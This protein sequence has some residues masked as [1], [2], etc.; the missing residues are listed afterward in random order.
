MTNETTPLRNWHKKA[1]RRLFYTEER[2]K[3]T[4]RDWLVMLAVTLCYATVAFTNLGVHQIAK[5]YYVMDTG[6]EVRVAFDKPEDIEYIKYY[7]SRVTGTKLNDNRKMSVSYSL[8]GEGYTQ[9]EKEVEEKD[10]EGNAVQTMS[11]E[12]IDHAFTSMYEWQFISVSF[13]AKYV[14]IH[15]DKGGLPIIEMAF[16]DSEGNPVKVASAESLEPDAESGSDVWNMFDEQQYVPLMTDYMSE[17]YFD[18][19]YH[20]RTGYEY[21]TH[22]RV[23][24]WTHPP[25]G[26]DILSVGI[27]I[28]GMN[29]FGWRCMGT[30]FG[31]LMLP[32]MYVLGKRMF[33]KTLYAFI[34]T[35]LMAVDFMHYTQ[36]RIATIDSYSVF[37]IMLMY[38][39]MYLYTETNYNREPLVNTLLPLSL[40]GVAFGLGAATKWL[41][42]YA[43][44]GLAVLLF[45]QLGKRYL[46]YAY[47]RRMLADKIGSAVLSDERRSYLEEITRGYIRRTLIT[48]LWCVLFFIIVPLGLYIISY[49]PYMAP[50]TDTAGFA[51]RYAYFVFSG[52]LILSLFVMWLLKMR[53]DRRA[54]EKTAAGASDSMQAALH[55][56][57]D[58]QAVISGAVKETE[59]PQKRSGNRPQRDGKYRL[60]RV[61]AAVLCMLTLAIVG[62]F[63]YY[64]SFVL[65]TD[66]DE[67]AYD[68]EA[69]LKNQ[70]NMLNYHNG[71]TSPHSYSSKWYQ[72]PIDVKPMCFFMG[73]GYPEGTKPIMYTMGN[74]AVWWGGVA[75]VITLIVIRIRKGRFGKRTFFISVAA[76][77]QYLPWVLVSRTVF[78]YHYFATVPFMILLMGVFAKY[79][80]ERTRRGKKFVFV[81]LGVALLLFIIY[82]PAITGTVLTKAYTDTFMQL[83]FAL[84]N[85]G[86]LY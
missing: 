78:I 82:Y 33:K 28:F 34:P 81:Y 85:L 16:C 86:T 52:L 40:A 75:T 31:V 64:I 62:V 71:V 8:D 18:E 2:A 32:V 57:D 72:W 26:K 9:L 36:T 83:P 17:M 29:P 19:V 13:T 74:P 68:F 58:A 21:I 10:D 60:K 67:G 27:Y 42:I 47:A 84:Y 73:D 69:L 39:F 15:V 25:L 41:C 6:D 70:E 46:E 48:L 20:A 1:K 77:S 7:A 3:F 55:E 59:A 5:T 14:I 22:L 45:V 63:I 37:F 24:E 66:V 11:T 56:A 12:V 44:A 43:G 4:L 51:L 49:A 30:L 65:Y 80:I 61:T 50:A 35:F 38:L 54:E 79:L 23:Y 53:N 76:I